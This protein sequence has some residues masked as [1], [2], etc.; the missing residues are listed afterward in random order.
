MSHPGQRQP[1]LDDIYYFPPCRIN[2]GTPDPTTPPANP[3]K[4][5]RNR[6][7]SSPTSSE[8]SPPRPQQTMALGAKNVL[9]TIPVEQVKVK[10]PF[11]KLVGPDT[12]EA[13]ARAFRS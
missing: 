2:E 9:N 7:R 13:Y 6:H 5:S 12:K 8:E 11:F 1:D 4:L 10:F 3:R